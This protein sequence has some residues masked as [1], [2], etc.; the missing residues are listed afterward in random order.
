[1]S[2][3]LEIGGRRQVNTDGGLIANGEPI[4]ASGLRQIV[5]CVQQLRGRAGDRQVPGG[6]EHRLHPGVRNAGIG[7][8]LRARPMTP[9]PLL[10]R[11]GDEP[12]GWAIRSD[13]HGGATWARLADATLR[14]A[15]ALQACDL[16][17]S[18]PGAGDRPQPPVDLARPVRAARSAKPA[19]CRS[20]STSPPA[21]SPTSPANPGP[22]WP[23]SIRRRGHDGRR[24]SA[25]SSIVIV[26]ALPDDGIAGAELDEFAGA[27]HR[28]FGCARAA[29]A[30]PNLLFTSG[31]TGRPKAVQ[32]PPKTIGDSADLAGFVDHITTHRLAKLGTH[33]VV[34]PL[35][36][37]GPLTA[38]R[39]M[40]AGVP[41]VVHERFDAEGTLAAIAD[42][43]D[44]E[45]DHG[46]HPLR[47]MPGAAGEVRER[48]D[49]SSLRQVAHTG[50][51]CRDRRQAGDDRV[52]GT[53][54]VRVVRR[55]RIR[56]RVLDQL[57]RLVGSPRI[58]S[59]GRCHRS[60]R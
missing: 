10:A 13:T 41:V 16:G 55:H 42:E 51:K 44:R 22:A 49:V 31:T 53:G 47:A 29:G 36:H 8:V 23:S 60:R 40:L 7:V 46:A 2:G 1:M 38:V 15:A 18:P 17:T 35:Y 56:H 48:Y 58:Q 37:N 24:R 33:L 39:L 3:E 9:L 27:G 19:R 11:A 26:V 12:D 43:R 52:V 28:P 50:G 6:P 32:L 25:G 20:T 59:A 57:D 34:G 54:V 30:C 4:G 45:L 21:R 14:L 5:E